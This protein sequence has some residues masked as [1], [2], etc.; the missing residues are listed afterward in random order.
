MQAAETRNRGFLS[1]FFN[2]FKKNKTDEGISETDNLIKERLTLK[3]K[4]DS[5]LNSPREESFRERHICLITEEQAKKFESLDLNSY[6]SSNEKS[7]IPLLEL[8]NKIIEIHE[9]SD[10]IKSVKLNFFE[11][12]KE[13]VQKIVTK[14]LELEDINEM[15]DEVHESLQ[16][17]KYA[18]NSYISENLKPYKNHSKEIKE[19][20][21][22]LKH[23]EKQ[24]EYLRK[25]YKSLMKKSK[26]Q[27]K[28]RQRYKN[29]AQAL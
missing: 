18:I 19:L 8:Q 15:L 26:N 3:I 2:I 22:P 5:P 13:K 7:L 11:N 17:L 14:H 16:D 20:R 12:D 24:I 9:S 23:L 25:S 27:I 10:K 6:L 4:E 1:P 28:F 21:T 29:V